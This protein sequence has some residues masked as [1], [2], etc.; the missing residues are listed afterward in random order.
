M[1]SD[2]A[3]DLAKAGKR[4]E[5][6]TSRLRYDDSEAQLPAFEVING[7]SVYRVWTSRFG[8][9]KPYWASS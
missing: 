1:L 2:L 6:V 5:I 4:V 3:F 8:R 9:G 7:V